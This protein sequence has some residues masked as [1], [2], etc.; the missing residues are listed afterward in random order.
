MPRR[1]GCGAVREAGKRDGPRWVCPLCRKIVLKLRYHLDQQDYRFWHEGLDDAAKTR[2]LVLFRNTALEGI[3]LRTDARELLERDRLAA[4]GHG[5]PAD[6]IE[7]ANNLPAVEDD[8]SL[9]NSEVADHEI[10]DG[11]PPAPPPSAPRSALA[12][13]C[14]A[15]GSGPPPPPPPLPQ[16]VEHDP[17]YDLAEVHIVKVFKLRTR[18][19]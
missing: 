5:S 13:S 16:A 4:E 3:H 1:A 12:S 2:L 18:P 6:D 11:P 8:E 10:A 15:M 14:R 17:N 19:Y 7:P 9:S